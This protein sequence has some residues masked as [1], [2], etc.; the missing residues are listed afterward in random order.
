MRLASSPLAAL[1]MLATVFLTLS[2]LGKDPVAAFKVFFVEPFGS[3]YGIGELLLKATPLMICALGLAVGYRANVWNIGAE[4]QF[5]MGAIAGSGIGLFHGAALGAGALPLML[6]A[7][8]LGGMA[9]AAIP[10]FL[11]ARFHTSEIFTSLMLVYIA[12]L[13][14]SYLVHGPWRDPAGQNFPQSQPFPDN[15]L[16]PPLFDGV[17]V[18]GG[19]ILG[20]VLAALSWWFGSVTAA[21]YRMRVSG[22]APAAA[23]YAG[24]SPRWNIWLALMISGGAAGLAGI[25]EVA[26]PIGVLQPVISPGYGFAA[27]IVAFVGRLH[28]IGIVLA[29][30]LMSALY[31]GGESAQIE[32][33]LPASVSGLFQGALLFFLLA[34]ELFIHFRLRRLRA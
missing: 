15:A 25:L 18:N 23:A 1:A 30:L 24:I 4:G 5:T 32:L 12:Q 10:A 11:R 27:I 8:V 13:F 22:L 14:L 16:L 9:W 6:T 21:G 31:L 3:L 33:Q 20:L 19:L 2:V 17:R 29:S 26:G 34:A 7:G 28:P